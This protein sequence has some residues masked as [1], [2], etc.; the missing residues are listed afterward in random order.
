[1]TTPYPGPE[2]KALRQERD[3]LS[4]ACYRLEVSVQQ[5]SA[6]VQQQEAMKLYAQEEA[7]RL[8]LEGEALRAQVNYLSETR[9]KVSAELTKAE[10]ELEKLR[11]R[12]QRDD[13]GVTIHACPGPGEALMP[14]CSRPPFEVLGD[15]MTRKPEFVNC[16]RLRIQQDLTSERYEAQGAIEGL[17][18]QNQLLGAELQRLKDQHGEDRCC[19]RSMWQ[20]LQGVN[21][22]LHMK[23]ERLDF[24]L[25]NLPR[26]EHWFRLSMAVSNE[27]EY[28]ERSE[29]LKACEEAC[30]GEPFVPR[31]DIPESQLTPPHPHVLIRLTVEIIGQHGRMPRAK[32]ACY[33]GTRAPF[34]RETKVR[35]ADGSHEFFGD[36]QYE[37]LCEGTSQECC[38]EYRRLNPVRPLLWTP[39]FAALEAQEEKAAGVAACARDEHEDRLCGPSKQMRCYRCG[40]HREMQPGEFV[41]GSYVHCPEHP[42]YGAEQ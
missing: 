25:R 38:A 33:V 31:K 19:P 15:R 41:P 4:V 5:L 22:D 40:R 34:S 37:V 17:E 27:G 39:E 42:K 30:G 14:C 18:R 6:Q 7:A 24:L 21:T 29:V 32:G 28:L 11:A 12:C 2:L 23:M 16:D 20:H 9:M 10:Q 8:R 35:M 26:F 1:M 13:E 36:H 3:D